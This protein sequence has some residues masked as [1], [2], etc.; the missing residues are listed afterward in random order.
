MSSG[1]NHPGNLGALPGLR[2][3]VKAIAGLERRISSAFNSARTH[4]GGAGQSFRRFAAEAV[5]D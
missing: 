1:V 4:V 3:G 2:F 5:S